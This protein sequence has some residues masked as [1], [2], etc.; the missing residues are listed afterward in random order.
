MFKRFYLLLIIGSINLPLFAQQTITK[1]LS[2]PDKDHTVLWDFYCTTGHKSQQWLKIPVPSNWEL[3]GFGTYN[4]FTDAE[5]PDL[6][7][8]NFTVSTS[9]TL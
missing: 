4:Y 1:Y 6:Y 5:N 8:Y 2:G 3:Q 9:V 7:K